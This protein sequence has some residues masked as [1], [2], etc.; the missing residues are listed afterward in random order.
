MNIAFFIILLFNLGALLWY[1]DQGHFSW[2][3][4]AGTLLTL[5]AL[6]M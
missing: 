2:G 6:E 5:I 3:N 4:L 1:A